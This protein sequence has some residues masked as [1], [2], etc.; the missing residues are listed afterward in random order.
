M[1][2]S[3]FFWRLG[4]TGVT[5]SDDVLGIVERIKKMDP[6]L[7]VQ[8]ID[9][10]SHPDLT[11]AP[12][13]IIEH[14]KDGMARVVFDTWTLDERVIKRLQMADSYQND[15]LGQLDM[16][17]AIAK[18]DRD[19]RFEE[20]RLE[21]KDI[22]EHVFKSPKGRYKFRNTNGKLITIDDG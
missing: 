15:I 9:P 13:R 8:F 16:A 7:D 10:E 6:N 5:V 18:I 3:E 20:A 22:V 1:S 11:E 17:N 19:R 12:Y 4:N 2:D 21:A 14:C